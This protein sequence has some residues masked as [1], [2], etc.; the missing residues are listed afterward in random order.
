MKNYFLKIFLLII[1]F[2]TTEAVSAFP[3]DDAVYSP[4]VKTILFFK[5]GFEMGQPV[6][7]LG[8]NEDLFLAFDDLDADSKPYKFTV[9]H[10]EAD[11]KTSGDIRPEEYIEGFTEDRIDDYQYSFNTLVP[12]T[13]YSLTFPT[14]NM[15]VKLSGNYLMVVYTNSAEEPVLTKRFMVVERSPMGITAEAHQATS[16]ELRWTKQEVDF[17]INYN[18]MQVYQPADQV[19]VVVTQN[20]RWDNAVRNIKPRFTRGESLDY[21]YDEQITF[22]GGNEFRAFDI[23]SLKYQ[24]ER[25]RRIDKESDVIKVFLLD[26]EKRTFKKYATEKDI[27]GR[28]LVKNEET[29][30]AS[31]IEADY[32]EVYFNL[33]F[34]AMRANGDM[35]I[36]GA[37]TNWQLDAGS[38]M[39]Y[40]FDTKSYKKM[41]LLKQGFFNYEYVFLD[42]STGKADESLVEGNHYETENEY[43]IW[44]YFRDIGGLYDKLVAVQNANTLK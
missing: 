30:G 15:K 28:R 23:K 41:L 20:D 1:I 43:T 32:V 34:D 9:I 17:T 24:T 37:L 12:Y 5:K 11:W 29:T 22:N 14:P 35:Y 38:R 25:I 39:S 16:P 6:I 44:V 31:D 13:H 10:C 36:L 8:E 7:K 2:F 19:K 21:N 42:K 18:G 40:D 27:N 3:N 26:D 4:S 33:P